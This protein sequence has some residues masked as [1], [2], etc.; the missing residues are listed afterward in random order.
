M[1]HVSPEWDQVLTNSFLQR[2]HGFFNNFT[3]IQNTIPKTVC[4]Y[5]IPVLKKTVI[6]ITRLKN[7][8]KFQFF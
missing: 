4:E 3:T 2:I 8:L 7:D 5:L 6:E 1:P